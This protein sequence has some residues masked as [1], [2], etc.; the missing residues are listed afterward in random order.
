MSWGKETMSPA[1]SFVIKID[2]FFLFF[3]SSF[4]SR[5]FYTFSCLGPYGKKKVGFFSIWSFKLRFPHHP[6]K[7]RGLL[8]ALLEKE[9]LNEAR[10]RNN[11]YVDLRSVTFHRFCKSLTLSKTSPGLYVSAVQL[12]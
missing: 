3:Y 11:I 1:F 2:V 9:S 6:L 4:F 8:K 12:F 10:N 5:P 7:T